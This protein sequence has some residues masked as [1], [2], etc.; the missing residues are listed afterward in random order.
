MISQ[1]LQPI[2][3]LLHQLSGI[4]PLPWFTFLGAFIEEV[5]APIPS[6]LV[7][8]LAGSMAASL[9]KDWSYLLIL[10]VIGATGK[11]I[12]SYII[13]VVADKA[14]DLI[15]GKFGKFVGISSKEIEVI[16]KHLNKGWRD[17]FVLILLRAIPIMPTAP[18]SIVCGLIKIN[19]KTYLS[20]TFIGTALRNM[21]Y[22]YLGFTSVGALESINEGID[23]FE[24]I[25]YVILLVLIAAGMLF[26]FQQRKKEGGLKLLEKKR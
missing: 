5:V 1:F 9:E 3:D 12:G 20:A 7:M 26:I 2:I 19:L 17:E 25:G 16:G 18:V 8:T 11:T 23:S 14:E 21:F 22:L 10:A 24:T 6:P 4:V 15:M 13:Y